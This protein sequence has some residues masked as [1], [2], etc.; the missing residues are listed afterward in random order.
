MIEIV[1]GNKN[2]PDLEGTEGTPGN[3]EDEDTDTDPCE[4]CE[5][6][7]CDP[8]KTCATKKPNDGDSKL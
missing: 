4:D 2:A 7:N 8:K 3:G 1:S 5:E 6:E